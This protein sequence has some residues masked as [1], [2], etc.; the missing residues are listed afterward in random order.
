M[1]RKLISY[2]FG[3]NNKVKFR[4]TEIR[5]QFT[6]V[7]TP[8]E[9]NIDAKCP[10]CRHELEKIPQRK[11]KCPFC[12][13]FMYI[14]TLPKTRERV[15]VSEQRKKEIDEEWYLSEMM[16]R[17]SISKEEYEATKSRLAEKFKC[18]PRNNDIWWT[19][20][21]RKRIVEI[22]KEHMGYYR[23]ITYEM[24]QLLISE[25]RDKAALR[26]LFEV[27]YLDCNDYHYFEDKSRIVAPAILS[28][29]NRIAKENHITKDQLK[30]KYFKE[31][32]GIARDIYPYT[33]YPVD[34]SFTIFEDQLT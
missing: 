7:N 12:K 22:S 34:K 13:Q 2:I 26:F 9:N 16:E 24:A 28:D 32:T 27:C 11:T 8:I 3:K 15:L 10:Y 29:I 30:E 17:Y 5:D 31:I 18:Q 4:A 33:K 21:N 23:M 25:G 14:R 6:P 1:L 20:F 19:L